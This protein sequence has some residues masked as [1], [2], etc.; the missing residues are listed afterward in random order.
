MSEE[1]LCR[2]KIVQMLTEVFEDTMQVFDF[3]AQKHPDSGDTPNFL[4]P[5]GNK[6]SLKTRGKSVLGHN[7][8]SFCNPLA[9]DDESGLPHILHAIASDAILYIRAKRNI[10]H[11][12]DERDYI[13]A[14]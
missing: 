11:P 1:Q 7:A 2:Y 3:G 6:C 9:L 13:N 4:T 5:A 10:V 12:E 8:S 14:V